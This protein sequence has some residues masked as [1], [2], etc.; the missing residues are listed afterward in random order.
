L[1]SPVL[2]GTAGLAG[3]HLHGWDRRRHRARLSALGHGGPGDVATSVLRAGA[4]AARR[5]AK[6]AGLDPRTID[7]QIGLTPAA[8]TAASFFGGHV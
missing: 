4:K 3:P 2:A 5:L 7:Q 1:R 6:R 8:R